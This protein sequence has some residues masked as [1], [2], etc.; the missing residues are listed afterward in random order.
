MGYGV[1]GYLSTNITEKDTHKGF[2]TYVRQR[3]MSAD[4]K[5]REDYVYLFFLLL[6]KELV[7]LK[8]CK[9]TYLRQARKLTNLT[10]DEV[11][12]TDKIDLPRYNRSFEVFKTMH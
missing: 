7:Q 8:R 12:N 11:M 3:I 4:S 6:V 2:A 5:Y 10:K 1:G 9:M